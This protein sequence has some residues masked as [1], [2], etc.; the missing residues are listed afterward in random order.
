MNREDNSIAS[1]Q[2]ANERN[3]LFSDS[4]LGG[5]IDRRRIL[6]MCCRHRK[7]SRLIRS[8][9]YR[10]RRRQNRTV[11]LRGFPEGIGLA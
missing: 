2:T 1:V 9:D 4:D 6:R 3:E 5:P 10:V 7:A 11:R 8:P